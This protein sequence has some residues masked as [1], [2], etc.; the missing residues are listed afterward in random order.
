M[1]TEELAKRLLALGQYGC[2]LCGEDGH[3]WIRPSYY[4]MD[5]ME[6]SH[7][8]YILKE[9]GVGLN[10]KIY[11]GVLEALDT[12]DEALRLAGKP[13]LLTGFCGWDSTSS[14]FLG[15]P[16][17]GENRIDIYEKGTGGLC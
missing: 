14:L 4:D 3:I 8:H 5:E 9:A 12:I 1:N 15:N 13:S 6:H 10:N 7:L 2:Y 17:I 11:G 16:G